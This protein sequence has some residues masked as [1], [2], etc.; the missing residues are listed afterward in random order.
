MF[1]SLKELQI[2]KIEFDQTFEPGEIDFADSA[3]RQITPLAAKGTARLLPNSGGQIRL[4]GS[5]RVG[6][7]TECDR[8]LAVTR[9]SLSEPFDLFYHPMV[10]TSAEEVEI[11]EGAAEL[12]FYKG[13][14]FQLA[15]A[16]RDQALLALPMQRVCREDC[17]GI[18]PVCG[19]DR[20]ETPC[21]CREKPSDERW[22]ALKKISITR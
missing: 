17:L 15:D 2:R 22:S 19:A 16:L 8:C 12:A 11:D 3:L 10:E 13:D 9:F 14:G 6:I 7:E 5:Y 21:Q 1:I 20:N 18:C 4:V